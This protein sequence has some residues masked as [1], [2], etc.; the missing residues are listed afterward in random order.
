MLN[1]KQLLILL[2]VY[3]KRTIVEMSKIFDRSQR[4]IQVLLGELERLGYLE[5]TYGPNGG[6]KTTGRHLMPGTIKLLQQ[7]GHKNIK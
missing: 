3:E 1:D 6:G 5:N 2:C 4:T 7:A